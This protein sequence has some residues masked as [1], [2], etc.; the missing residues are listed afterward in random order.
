MNPFSEILN[1]ICKK[2]PVNYDSKN[3]VNFIAIGK[4]LAKE[5]K[6]ISSLKGFGKYV[7]YLKGELPYY[8]LYCIVPY[9]IS[10][11]SK[12]LEDK[13]QEISPVYNRIKEVLGW[14]NKE[15]RLH[16][17]ILNK[18]IDEKYWKRNMGIK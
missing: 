11:Y 12:K 17:K 2:N 9:G 15:L 1:S 14:S 6:F 18:I 10:S 16:T 3:F 4:T 8:F 13:E 5:S 7:W